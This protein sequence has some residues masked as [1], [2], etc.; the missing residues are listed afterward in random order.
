MLIRMNQDSFSI[1]KS[2][3]SELQ[4]YKCNMFL[5]SLPVDVKVSDTKEF[6]EVSGSCSYLYVTLYRL[7]FNFDIELMQG[8]IMKKLFISVPMKDRT[9][10]EI[11]ESIEKM[12][13]IAEIY[14]GEELEVI[15]SY[16]AHDAPQ[17]C[18][19]GVYYLGLSIQQ[20]A[21]ADVFIGN[22]HLGIS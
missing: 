8:V 10:Q 20:L 16:I 21:T 1:V 13:K 17:T 18:S 22:N 11:K 5:K 9:K 14:E 3:L 2:S 7:T 12:K 4:H 15:D 19:E 6:F